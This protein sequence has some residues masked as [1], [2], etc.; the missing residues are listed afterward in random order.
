[1]SRGASNSR[2]TADDY[3]GVAFAVLLT[4]VG[5]F[6]LVFLAL[7]ILPTLFENTVALFFVAVIVLAA[8]LATAFWLYRSDESDEE[9]LRSR[10]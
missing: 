8:F 4:I 7:L 2:R 10:V 1:M 6:V 5:G 3:I 9:R